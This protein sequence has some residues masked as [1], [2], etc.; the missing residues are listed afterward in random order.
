MN[1]I[2]TKDQ[3][4]S[5]GKDVEVIFLIDDIDPE[6]AMHKQHRRLVGIGRFD[7]SYGWYIR[8]GFILFSCWTNPSNDSLYK[9]WDCITHWREMDEETKNILSKRGWD[10]EDFN[11]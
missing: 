5:H 11:A 8:N 10:K 7:H 2:R 6:N 9:K 4:P 3:I 1:W